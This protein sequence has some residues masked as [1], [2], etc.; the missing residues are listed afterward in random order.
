MQCRSVNTSDKLSAI[1]CLTYFLQEFS[2]LSLPILFLAQKRTWQN[3]KSLNNSFADRSGV[4][5]M[6]TV[7]TFRVACVY[8]NKCAVVYGT[9]AYHANNEHILKW[10]I[11]FKPKSQPCTYP[12][13]LLALQCIPHY[14]YTTVIT[15]K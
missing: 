5:V 9:R 6:Y 10:R 8:V 15:P 2:N 3:I 11:F 12:V 7:Y 13:L 4:H 14:K 1:F